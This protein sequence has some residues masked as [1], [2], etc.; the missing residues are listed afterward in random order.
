MLTDYL[1]YLLKTCYYKY[2]LPSVEIKDYIVLIDGNEF[3]EL[4]LKI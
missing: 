1:S 4:S 3:F 2:Y